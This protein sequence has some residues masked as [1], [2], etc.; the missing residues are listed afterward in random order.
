MT[1]WKNRSSENRRVYAA[2]QNAN[3][4][5]RFFGV[6]GRISSVD[7]RDLWG[8]VP[9]CVDC[10]AGY[11]LDHVL[12]MRNGGLNR[13]ENLT[14]RCQSCNARKSWCDRRSHIEEVA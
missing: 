14:N 3:A 8:R 1:A 2:V 12:S 9:R 5:A 13:P 11:G 10:G 6:E 4:R 7:L